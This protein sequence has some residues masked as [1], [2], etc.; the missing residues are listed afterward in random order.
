M[1]SNKIFREV[2]DIVPEIEKIAEDENTSA[3]LSAWLSGYL[4][5]S[6][7]ERRIKKGEM[8]DDEARTGS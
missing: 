3:N 4:E 8:S 7:L 2:K 6:R 1:K 5:R